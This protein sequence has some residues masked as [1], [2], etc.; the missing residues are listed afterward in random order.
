MQL[1]TVPGR[2]GAIAT[3]GHVAPPSPAI[4][5]LI[6]EDA[7]APR[8]GAA[9]NAP[10]LIED[11][12]VG[13]TL[14]DGNE[15]ASECVTHRDE[16]ARKSAVGAMLD[17]PRACTSTE[18]TIDLAQRGK[19]DFGGDDSTLGHHPQ[20]S[21]DAPRVAEHGERASRLLLRAASH[22][23]A[24]LRV[25]H[26]RSLQPEHESIEVVQCVSA[27]HSSIRVD[28]IEPETFGDER[29]RRA[30]AMARVRE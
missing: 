11:Q 10:E 12:R 2:L 8:V 29:E 28:E 19:A 20:H 23:G 16:R 25:E 6:L 3:R 14:D 9:P 17:S 13:G 30:I 1:H 21:T 7:P 4:L 22:R 15:Q 18:H 5:C 26:V 27:A 24:A